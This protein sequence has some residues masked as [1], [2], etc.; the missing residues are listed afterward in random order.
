MGL[1][2]VNGKR[3]EIPDGC[4]VS[5][6][7]NKVMVNGEVVTDCKDIVAK[8]ISIVIE[9]KVNNVS[10]TSGNISVHS[11]VDGNVTTTSGDISVC[12]S[13]GKNVTTTSGDVECG[14]VAGDVKTISGDI[15]YKKP[16]FRIG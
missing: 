1:C 5:I 3:Y 2:I 10:S 9:G 6:N 16:L 11:N 7:G 8:N 13:V 4:N 12:G 14:N 15:E